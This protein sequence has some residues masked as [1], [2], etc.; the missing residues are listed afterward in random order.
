M[1]GGFNTWLLHGNPGER[2]ADGA[3][4]P[5]ICQ[6]NAFVHESAADHEAVFANRKY[7][8][9]Y[10]RVANP[11]VAALERTV[12][13]IE[14]GAATVAYGSGMA[15]LAACFMSIAGHD[16]QIVAAPGLYGGTVELLGL[17]GQVGIEVVYAQDNTP[18]A[19]EGLVGKRTRAVFCETIGNP[20]LDIADIAGLAQ[21]AH[22]AGVPLV[23][24]NTAATPYLIRALDAGADIVVNSTSKFM[25][26]SSNALGGTLTYSGRFTW[27]FNKFWGLAPFARFRE[28][29]LIPRLRNDVS[30]ALGGCMAPQSAYYT[31]VGLETLGLRMERICANAQALAEHLEA[32]EAEFGIR[33]S[34]PGL[35]SH[36]QHE[37]ARC[38]FDGRYGAILT[39][40]LGTRERAYRL[41]DALQL[42]SIVSNIGDV[43]TLAVHP[44]T[45]IAA[46]LTPE[47]QE[48]SG[49]YPDLV[50]VC[51]G[52]E[53]A[54]DL[55]DDFDQALNAVQEGD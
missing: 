8:F 33:V 45:T 30:P 42:V 54:P 55:I 14:G 13:R 34:Y 1:A 27:D 2:Y 28:M 39:L 36:P 46:H 52:I 47:Q 51:V 20:R 50:R 24:D 19:Y 37:L 38:Q 44:A 17:L 5:P 16:D 25:D 31:L 43:R 18:A 10:S 11:T 15:A 35:E 9:A 4:L 22:A 23:V 26:G 29:A 32:L 40:R 21:V 6:A 49:V 41:L 7:G 3:T 12:N 53:D 48:A